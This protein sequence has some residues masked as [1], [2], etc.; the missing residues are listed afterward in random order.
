M[1]AGDLFSAPAAAEQPADAT[2]SAGPGSD[3]DVSSSD[4]GD[5]FAPE[6]PPET[7]TQSFGG[8]T[9]S[10][11]QPAPPAAGAAAAGLSAVMRDR[12]HEMLE[13]VAWEAFADLSETIVKQVLERAEQIAWEVIPQM[14]EIAIHEEI[15]RI[16]G[17][18]E[19]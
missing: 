4:L 5:P 14:A 9:S 2:P 6:P 13:K 1:L 12:V 18:D 16:K 19:S 8:P 3:Y 7:P 17:D 10:T 11:A 15:R